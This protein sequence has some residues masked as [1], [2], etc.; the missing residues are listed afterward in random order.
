M[1]DVIATCVFGLLVAVSMW[2]LVKVLTAGTYCDGCK[3]RMRP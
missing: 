3:R 1:K 2:A